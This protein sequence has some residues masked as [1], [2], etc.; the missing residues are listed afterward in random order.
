[1]GQVTSAA[2]GAGGRRIGRRGVSLHL[3]G[4]VASECADR[5]LAQ[6]PGLF[7]DHV[8]L[9][10]D[11]G[12]RLVDVAVITVDV[13]GAGL[14]LRTRLLVAQQSRLGQAPAYAVLAVSVHVDLAKATL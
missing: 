3:H 12:V 7:E 14:D 13:V 11:P 9:V 1:M 6:F 2:R 10:E 4:G 8:S 5:S